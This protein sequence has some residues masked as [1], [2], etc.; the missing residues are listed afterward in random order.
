VD[1]TVPGSRGRKQNLERRLAP[2]PSPP[3][4]E[5]EL[6]HEHRKNRILLQTVSRHA[7][8]YEFLCRLF[9]ENERQ[10]AFMCLRHKQT[11]A[12][13][14]HTVERYVQYFLN[15]PQI[16]SK[17]CQKSQKRVIKQVYYEFEPEFTRNI[18]ALLKELK[19]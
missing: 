1:E 10:D 18:E 8:Q 16:L 13:V 11:G 3:L 7:K 19:I 15:F 2:A 14:T 6:R 12:S 5:T 17:S 9:T 4:I